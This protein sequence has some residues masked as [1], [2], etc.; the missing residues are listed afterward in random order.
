MLLCS[1]RQSVIANSPCLEALSQMHSP[2]GWQS[3]WVKP[4][5]TFATS[6]HK[7]KGLNLSRCY[8]LASSANDPESQAGAKSISH[9]VVLNNAEDVGLS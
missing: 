3:T 6:L 4:A 8:F 2:A 5:S 1:L 9:H 7:N